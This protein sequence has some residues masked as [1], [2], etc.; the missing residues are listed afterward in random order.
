MYQ[1]HPRWTMDEAFA[2][3]STERQ[4]SLVITNS[5]KMHMLARARMTAVDDDL[6]Q[7]LLEAGSDQH[8]EMEVDDDAIEAAEAF[9]AMQVGNLEPMRHLFALREE[10]QRTCHRCGKKVG[11]DPVTGK[12]YGHYIA[13]CPMAPGP[14]ERAKKPMRQWDTNVNNKKAVSFHDP[15]STRVFDRPQGGAAIPPR[16]VHVMSVPNTFEETLRVIHEQHVIHMDELKALEERNEAR[17]QASLAPSLARSSALAI[18]G[19][20]HLNIISGAAEGSSGIA[21]GQRMAGI[22]SGQQRMAEAP[23]FYA[24]MAPA[25]YRM[26]GKGND[27]VTELW[28]HPD[29]YNRMVATAPSMTTSAAGNDKGMAQ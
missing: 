10:R 3:W 16:P 13:N 25:G 21:A 23:V 5:K 12:P 29:D 20:G 6:R 27:G 8:H 17:F 18:E 7:D 19:D 26:I 11:I 24:D 4:G 2:A 15:S 28:V 1:A 14:Q 22:A 9:Q